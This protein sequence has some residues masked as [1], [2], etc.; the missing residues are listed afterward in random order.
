MSPIA[1]YDLGRARGRIIIDFDDKGTQTAQEEF[2]NVEESA[3]E[4]MS[5]LEKF[6]KLAGLVTSNFG[7]NARRFASAFGVM[8]GGT[9]ILVG[10]SRATG[11]FSGSVFRMR[12]ALGIF[13]SL[14][15]LLGGLPKKVEGFPK[16]IKQIILLSSAITL[17]AKSSKLLNDVFVQIGKFIGSTKIIQSLTKAFPWLT[18]AI[19][20]MAKYIPSLATVG[21]TINGWSKPIHQIA[22]MALAI[23]GLIQLFRNGTKAALALTKGILK[24]G[25]GAMVIQG[26]I[27]VVA[28]LYDALQQ[29]SGLLGLLPGAFAVVG[30]AAATV[31]I[32]LQGFADAMKNMDDAAAFEESLKKLAPSAQDAARAI[33]SLSDDW[34]MLQRHVQQNLFAG[35]AT[36]IK[37]LGRIYLPLLYTQLGHVSTELNLMAKEFAA[38]FKQTSTQRDVNL[39]FEAIRQTLS[40]LRPLIQPILS[41]LVDVFVVSAQVFAEFSGQLNYATQG[42]AEFIHEARETGKLAQW[43]RDGVA[44]FKSLIEIIRNT[45]EIMSILFGA[46]DEDSNGFLASL[47]QMTQRIKVFLMSAEGQQI[48]Q[49]FVDLLSTLSSVTR[50]VLGAGLSELGPIIQSLLPFLKEMATTI[51][52]VLVTAIKILGPIINAIAQAL[53]AMAPVLG[54][55]I[56][57][58]LA[59]SITM[60]ALTAILG[61]TF[62]ALGL[63]ASAISTVYTVLKVLGG[64]LVAH[65]MFAALLLLATIAYL[66]IDN[67]EVVG[68]KLKAIWEWIA[69]VATSVW[70]AIVN[71]FKGLWEDVSGFFVDTWNDIAG[72]ATSIWNEIT[73]FLSGIWDDVSGAFTDA[74]NAISTFLED[75]WNWIVE[76]FRFIWEP[77]A[78]II[79]SILSIIYDLIYIVIGG[80]IIFLIA[81][82]EEIRTATIE[83]W[84]E[85]KAALEG[86]WNFIMEIFHA[87]WDPLVEAWN[88]LWSTISTAVSDA[89]N[90]MV[91][92]LTAKWNEAVAVWHQ[93]FDPIIEWWNSFW[94]GIADWITNVWNSITSFL[95]EKFAMLRN[96]FQTTWDG[97]KNFF[98]KIWNSDIVKSVRDGVNKVVEFVK[99]LPSRI[100]NFVKDAGRWLWDAGKKVI[101]GFLNGLKDAFREVADWVSGIADWVKDHKGPLPKDK[102]LLIP[103]GQAIMDSLLVGLMSK[104]QMIKQFLTG[105]TTDIQNGIG[106]AGATL[107]NAAD[108]LTASATLGIVS[109]I[110]TNASALASAVSPV[111]VAAKGTP[112]GSDGATAPGATIII[113]KLE[114]HVAGNL[115]PTN[116]VQWRQAMQNIQEGIRGV[117]KGYPANG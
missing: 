75:S 8:A 65:P 48:L 49:S 31:K 37:A 53:S 80:I 43:I 69:G 23:G 19:G 64:F 90:A 73:G 71:F 3:E 27:F 29:L 5:V 89:W 113:D 101:S 100:W 106:G 111:Q 39:I 115:D 40:N 78:D 17:A 25:A 98:N 55:I 104:E 108:G 85:I 52:V 18:N 13:G 116:P 94:Q 81:A 15:L 63:L 35:L 38:F 88:W 4:L 2:A 68:P 9:A 33:R 34:R 42:F 77:M 82:W 103:A 109:S 20:S 36:E 62:T 56:G 1:D 92:W 112:T 61:L 105:L 32:G 54:P 12:G 26:L 72:F 58:F 96:M 70:N 107:N 21:S 74:W 7:D 51:S 93:I 28:G 59:W 60:S 24:M 110:P 97:I 50:A 67:W 45:S 11:L 79:K 114:L 91:E 14:G 66:I 117:N 44:G 84:N 95:G 83:T 57:F 76:T 10:L 87:I 30:V 16:I 41:I 102:K 22:R 46:F 99:S 47:E 86:V 6:G